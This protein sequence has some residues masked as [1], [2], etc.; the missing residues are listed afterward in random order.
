MICESNRYCTFI[1]ISHAQHLPHYRE[2]TETELFSNCILSIEL[3]PKYLNLIGYDIDI[4][5]TMCSEFI[6]YLSV[7]NTVL[8]NN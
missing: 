6:Y 4:L 2:T 7:Q 1:Y 3:M 5:T 8:S